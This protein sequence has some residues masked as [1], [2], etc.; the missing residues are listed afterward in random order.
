[1][2]AYLWL[3]LDISFSCSVRIHIWG[4]NMVYRQV[5]SGLKPVNLLEFVDNAFT[6]CV[7][8]IIIVMLKFVVYCEGYKV[9]ARVHRLGKSCK[10]VY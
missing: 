7:M 10:V 1:M 6:I 4:L 9:D 3:L 5:H 8:V 2:P